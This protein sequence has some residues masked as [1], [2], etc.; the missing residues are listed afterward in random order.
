MG[1]G[2][3]IEDRMLEAVDLGAGVGAGVTY[4]SN[5]FV[6]SGL[7]ACFELGA[8]AGAGAGEGALDVGLDFEG[9]SVF[10]FNKELVVFFFL[11]AAEDPFF[12]R[13][14]LS[15][16]RNAALSDS[17][18]VNKLAFFELM[19]GAFELLAT[20]TGGGAARVA[21]VD[22]FAATPVVTF[23][24]LTISLMLYLYEVNCSK[25]REKDQNTDHRLIIYT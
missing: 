19:A 12:V 7:E 20:S 11:V 23:F 15:F 17:D 18:L 4:S 6:A 5:Q 24:L 9:A 22:F 8:G 21:V 13:D 10:P 25:S 14:L 3:R 2:E 1:A 16:F